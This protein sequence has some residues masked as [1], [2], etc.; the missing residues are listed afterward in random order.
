[1]RTAFF[2]VD[3]LVDFL[4]PA[5]ALYVPGAEKLMP[6][7]SKLA[8]YAEANGIPV[9]STTDAHAEDDVEFRDWP[10]HC[11]AGTWGQKKPAS[12]LLE[13]RAVVSPGHCEFP[14]DAGQVILEKQ[15]LDSF[16]SPCLAGI[17]DR[18]GAGRYVVYGV[19]TEYC[20]RLA[21]LG[22][23]KTG[24][25][26]ELV[27]DAVE[28]LDE[29]HSRRTLEEFTAAGGVLTTSAEVMAEARTRTSTGMSLA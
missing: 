5:G 25:R 20:V 4:Y 24:R 7:L 9:I 10:P 27:T 3:T 26:V 2:D 22:L 29:E 1:M 15:T 19:V 6:V 23:L 17:L 11:V 21:A 13:N 18:I 8:R 16:E 28:T 14:E 12:L